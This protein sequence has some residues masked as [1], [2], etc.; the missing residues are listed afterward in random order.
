MAAVAVNSLYT[1]IAA[2]PATPATLLCLANAQN[3]SFTRAD[4]GENDSPS[5]HEIA[6]L[7]QVLPERGDAYGVQ[8]QLSVELCRGALPLNRAGHHEIE[9]TKHVVGDLAL[10]KLLFAGL[11]YQLPDAIAH[12][13]FVFLKLNISARYRKHCPTGA[14][15]EMTPNLEAETGYVG[16][17]ADALALMDHLEEVELDP[18]FNLSEI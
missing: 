14:A 6:I 2:T 13:N 10:L 11:F 1:R 3:A 9:D 18:K 8:V 5:R 7:G 12:M 16:E 4:A 15:I 17:K